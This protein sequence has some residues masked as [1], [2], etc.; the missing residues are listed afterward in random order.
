MILLRHTGD[1]AVHYAMY[2][3]CGYSDNKL[4]DTMALMGESACQMCQTE[5][6]MQ[7]RGNDR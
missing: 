6:D 7:C 4:G 5:E 2:T 3:P 1:S